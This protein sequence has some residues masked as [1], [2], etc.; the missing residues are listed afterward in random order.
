MG[1]G[2][3]ESTFHGRGGTFLVD[4]PLGTDEDYES[5]LQ[6]CE[7]DG[8]DALSREDWSQQ[9]YD[10]ENELLLD[11]ATTAAKEIGL[12][13]ANRKRFESGYA[14][15]DREFSLLA[16]DDLV[17][18]GW[19]SWQHD[20]VIGVGPAAR[21]EQKLDLDAAESASELG[22]SIEGFKADY[23]ALAAAVLEYVRIKIAQ[24]GLDC[25]YR[26]SGYTTASYSAVEDPQ[27]KLAELTAT[28]SSLREKLSASREEAL[29]R[30]SDEERLVVIEAALDADQD[31][32]FAVADKKDPGIHLYS[33]ADPDGDGCTIFAS[34]IVPAELEE[35]FASLPADAHVAVPREPRTEAWFK[36]RQM[37]PR[38]FNLIASADEIAAATGS[39]VSIKVSASDTDP[40]LITQ[41]VMASPPV[42]APAVGMG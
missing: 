16:E 8:V 41:V 31:V 33:A 1:V 2:V 4:G 32:A 3:Y 20:F 34:M 12:S 37:A 18:V 15:F 25:R 24:D 21:A 6:A 13:A 38:E 14:S 28:I 39:E 22:R 17:A 29:T 23:D 7:S 9:E 5:H 42:Q 11:S 19:R 40:D 26:T 35:W 27:A 30:I 10:D 36:A